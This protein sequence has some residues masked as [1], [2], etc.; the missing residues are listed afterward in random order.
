MSAKT[1]GFWM[2]A[3][4][5]MMLAAGAG[6]AERGGLGLTEAQKEQ[7]QAIRKE[8][9]EKVARAR[10]EGRRKFLEILTPD[11][12]EKVETRRKKR[13]E[14]LEARLRRLKED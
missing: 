3:V 13:I 12:R 4:A 7:A 9:R 10:K 6:A 5:G 1:R 2:V 14:R 11:Q 8:T